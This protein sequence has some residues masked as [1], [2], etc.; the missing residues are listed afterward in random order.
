MEQIFEDSTTRPLAADAKLAG[1]VLNR[2]GGFLSARWREND[3]QW[4]RLDAAA[5]I[6]RI[7]D[8]S[9]RDDL[10]TEPANVQAMVGELQDS[11]LLESG[12]TVGSSGDGEPIA[13]AAGSDTLD[14]IS[15][16]YRYSLA[17]RIA[18]LLYRALL[19]SR[20]SALSFQNIGLYLAQ[21][22]LRLLMVP[23]V[24]IADPL[25]LAWALVIVLGSAATLGAGASASEWLCIS[26]LVLVGL[27]VW[28]CLRS[29][30]A[31]K[32]GS[33]LLKR[34]DQ[35][36]GSNPEWAAEQWKDVLLRADTGRWRKWS[37][38]LA[39]VVMASAFYELTALVLRL[40]G[41]PVHPVFSV[42]TEAFLA[43]LFFVLFVQHF[44]NQRAYRVQAVSRRNPG[45]KP[46]AFLAGAAAVGVVVVAEYV[47]HYQNSRISESQ[48]SQGIS[49][50]REAIGVT[51]WWDRSPA[52]G[53]VAAV[54]VALLT[55]LS[56]WGWTSR[57]QATA[58]IVAAAV[59]AG[60][61]Q[62]LIDHGGRFCDLLPALV[63][64]AMVAVVHPV[65]SV[66]GEDQDYGETRRPVLL[67]VERNAS[68]SP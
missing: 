30:R 65:I 57:W 10:G 36:G 50:L 17:A 6:A 52:T 48:R 26:S 12:M 32:S 31:T 51:P 34:L 47:A 55:F 27:A 67:T 58:C 40:H 2:F 66:R 8:S 64:M 18:P 54:A 53:L 25:R 45:R 68:T 61:V 24:L 21:V 11:I 46:L 4:G 35:I 44:L 43:W 20:G 59:G 38:L 37:L 29:N 56:L 33:T 22:P 28:I 19:P 60:V 7:M 62:G 14:T 42:T 5:G 15:P 39:G 41:G 9:R 49:T 23:L 1:N 16:R 3:W 13:L 63:W